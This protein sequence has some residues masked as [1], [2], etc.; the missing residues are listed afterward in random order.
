MIV[1]VRRFLTCSA[2]RVAAKIP[3]AR[4]VIHAPSSSL[5][6][7]LTASLCPS[8]SKARRRRYFFSSLARS[9]QFWRS[10]MAS[11]SQSLLLCLP[12]SG[13]RH[14]PQTEHSGGPLGDPSARVFEVFLIVSQSSVNR[15]ASK[16]HWGVRYIFIPSPPPP[17]I[18]HQVPG[19]DISP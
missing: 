7:L 1:A 15:Y 10:Q 2:L 8:P 17:E 13:Q 12:L 6:A 18:S 3:S 9:S 4:H 11:V 5:Q 14:P 19:G 16:M